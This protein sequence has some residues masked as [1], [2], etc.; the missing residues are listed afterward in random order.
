LEK[1]YRFVAEE[2]PAIAVVRARGSRYDG[3]LD[4]FVRGKSETVRVEYP[5]K[6][7]NNLMSS[8]RARIRVRGLKAK[9]ALRKGRVYL[10]KGD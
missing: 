3:L 10:T 1:P 5:G 9:V 4:D 2:L 7:T 6:S 8:L